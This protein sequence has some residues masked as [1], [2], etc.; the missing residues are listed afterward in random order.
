[1]DALAPLLRSDDR[2]APGPSA[3]R[4]VRDLAAR[5]P[6]RRQVMQL[7]LVGFRG[8]APTAPFVGGLATRDWGGV[9]IG[10]DNYAKGRRRSPT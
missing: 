2:P 1:M 10:H 5:L 9:L 7:F 8:R 4:S 6:L 3:P